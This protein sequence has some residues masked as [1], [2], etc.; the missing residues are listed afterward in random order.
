MWWGEKDVRSLS[1]GNITV[2]LHIC[3]RIWDGF[4]KNE[5]SLPDRKRTDLLNGGT[6]DRDIQATGILF[7]SNEWFNKL[8]EEPGGNA[9][10]SFVEKLGTRL[11]ERMLSDLSMSYPGGNG[12]SVVLSEY[13]SEA[14]DVTDLQNFVREAV[15]YGV[16]FETEHS[17]KSKAGGR[18]V[19]L[20]LNPILCPRF[21]L[22]EARTKEPCYWSI[23]DL[24]ELAKRAQITPLR[25]LE[26]TNIP[27]IMSLYCKGGGIAYEDINFGSQWCVPRN[28]GDD[29]SVSRINPMAL[30]PS[31]DG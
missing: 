10:K 18:R 21:Q 8:P 15:G 17:S 26:N 11:N 12:I 27:V 23:D 28:S 16:L 30:S 14:Y 4:L 1:G 31:S 29:F 25:D 3:H 13:E 19:K 6:I 2:F 7:A 22:P 9:R 20:Y 24:F 5:S